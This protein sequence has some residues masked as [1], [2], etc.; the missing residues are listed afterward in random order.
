MDIG[1]GVHTGLFSI[2]ES[3]DKERPHRLVSMIA[4]GPLLLFDYNYLT[5]LGI[6][7]PSST[8]ATFLGASSLMAAANRLGESITHLCLCVIILLLYPAALNYTT[9]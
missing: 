5:S 7:S 3:S 4:P 9:Q 8:K 1:F 6:H 2:S